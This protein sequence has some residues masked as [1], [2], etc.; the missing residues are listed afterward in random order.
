MSP[1]SFKRFSSTNNN[2]SQVRRG[3]SGRRPLLQQLLPEVSLPDQQRPTH[4]DVE[5]ADDALLK[6]HFVSC[7]IRFAG[8]PSRSLLMRRNGRKV[9]FLVKN[10]FF[11]S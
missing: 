7:W 2:P 5:E 3:A 11:F 1:G 10:N 8:I 4:V 6:S 9:S